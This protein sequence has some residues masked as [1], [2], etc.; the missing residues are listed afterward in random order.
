V[1]LGLISMVLHALERPHLDALSSHN[2]LVL[3]DTS[4]SLL[5]VPATY[6]LQLHENTAAIFSGLLHVEK[7]SFR[8][9]ST[10]I[11]LV[12]KYIT[13]GHIFTPSSCQWCLQ[14]KTCNCTRRQGPF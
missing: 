3:M 2:D 11:H 6:N 14:H 12:K 1:E 10:C 4:L 5:L 9:V 8:C 13:H 7:A